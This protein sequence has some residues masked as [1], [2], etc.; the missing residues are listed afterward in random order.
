MGKVGLPTFPAIA[1]ARG[2]AVAARIPGCRLTVVPGAD[3]LL[4]LRA[5]A[6]TTAAIAELNP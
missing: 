3:H 1:A 2:A 4:P 5:P 6:A